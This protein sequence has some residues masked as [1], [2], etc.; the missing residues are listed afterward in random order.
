[1]LATNI[2]CGGECTIIKVNI[3]NYYFTLK[4]G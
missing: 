3:I 1:M 2:K 4:K